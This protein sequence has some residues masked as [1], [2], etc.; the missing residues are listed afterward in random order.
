MEAPLEHLLVVLTQKICDGAPLSDIVA[1]AADAGPTLC[2]DIAEQL[3]D[4]ETQR[5]FF[6][7]LGR[8]VWSATPQPGH[9]YAKLSATRPALNELCDCGSGRPYRHCCRRTEH[10]P[11]LPDINTLPYLLQCLPK[12]RWA[13]LAGSQIDPDEVAATAEEFLEVGAAELAVQLLEPWLRKATAL[14]AAHA[15]IYDLL[16]DAYSHLGQP[17]KKQRLLQAMLERGDAASRA[18]ALQRQATMAADEGDHDSAW[19]LFLAAQREAPDDPALAHLEISLLIARGDQELA[20]RRAQFWAARLA[21]NADTPPALLE[22]LRQVSQEGETALFDVQAQH[23]P[24]LAAL[25]QWLAALPPP[26]VHYRFPHADDQHCG[27]M[28][29][30]ATLMRAEQRW[31]AVAGGGTLDA[32]DGDPSA[33][34]E[35]LQQQPVLAQSFEVLEILLQLIDDAQCFGAEHLL[36]EPLLQHAENLL[37][38]VL[39]KRRVEGRALEWGYLQNRP[40]L[41]LLGRRI[42]DGLDTAGDGTPDDAT[43]ARLQWLVET[44]NPNDNQGF[45]EP[46]LRSLLLAGED[47]AALALCERYPKDFLVGITYGRVLCL[48]RLGRERAAQAALRKAAEQRPAV[49]RYL[50]ADKPRQPRLHA[51]GVHLGGNDEAWLH[52]IDWRPVW[53]QNGAL[54]WLRAESAK[55]RKAGN[56]KRS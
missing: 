33:L 22:F 35:L 10:M 16:L 50:L 56:A 4:A 7:A 45:R 40:A 44:L 34:I 47:A 31:S 18:A 21:R 17:R 11:E 5:H 3:G 8:R 32:L 24:W 41:R 54:D 1:Y 28:Q 51:E 2:A 30:D 15:N 19:Q 9:A 46:L 12:K 55:T 39:Q 49:L 48:H 20:Q 38:L 43:L 23:M 29:A 27:P 36:I 13:E 52:R 42:S 14:Q 25:R 37:H 53:E 6:A 26:S